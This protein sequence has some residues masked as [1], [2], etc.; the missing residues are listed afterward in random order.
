MCPGRV[1]S[2]CSISGTCR[3][4]ALSTI[5]LL[6]RGGQFYWS[7]KPEYLEKT[8]DLQQVIDKL[9]HIMLYRLLLVVFLS[10]TEINSFMLDKFNDSF[11]KCSC[12]S[13][14]HTIMSILADFTCLEIK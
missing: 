5:F 10:Y 4:T 3:L 2:S 7:W 9:Y 1:N 8:T 14:Y 11:G 12:K 6:Y 13:N